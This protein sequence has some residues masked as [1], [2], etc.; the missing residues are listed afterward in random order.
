MIAQGILAYYFFTH[1]EPN[2]GAA[3]LTLVILNAC[4]LS[5]RLIR[6]ALR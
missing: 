1:G 3:F 5:F 6:K 2:Y 4:V